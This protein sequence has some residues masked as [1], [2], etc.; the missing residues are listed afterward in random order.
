VGHTADLGVVAK[1]KIAV[2]NGNLIPAVQPLVDHVKE[3]FRIV[4][5]SVENLQSYHGEALMR[6]IKKRTLLRKNEDTAAKKKIYACR[7]DMNCI[8]G[9][10]RMVLGEE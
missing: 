8:A 5:S 9:N 7:N 3:P 6:S 2:P 10:G 4:V 1:R